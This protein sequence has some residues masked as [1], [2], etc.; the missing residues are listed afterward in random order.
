MLSYIFKNPAHALY[1]KIH[2]WV[3][4]NVYCLHK[5]QFYQAGT[6]LGQLLTLFTY[7]I[8]FTLLPTFL[9]SKINCLYF[10]NFTPNSDWPTQFSI[11][12]TYKNNKPL[13]WDIKG[14]EVALE[15]CTWPGQVLLFMGSH[16]CSRVTSKWTLVTCTHCIWKKKKSLGNTVHHNRTFLLLPANGSQTQKNASLVKSQQSKQWGVIKQK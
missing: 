16:H 10:F 8:I 12:K 13:E 14:T 5:L 1:F 15:Y 2:L 7:T 9:S 4:K 11:L 3:F 6:C